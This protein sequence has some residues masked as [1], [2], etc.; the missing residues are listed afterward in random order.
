[1]YAWVIITVFLIMFIAFILLKM[2][3]SHHYAIFYETKDATRVVLVFLVP[4]I[5]GEF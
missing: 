5:Q 2:R 4:K 1:M 3:F